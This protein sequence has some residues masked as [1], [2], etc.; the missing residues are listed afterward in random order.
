M[1]RFFTCIFLGTLLALTS[2]LL[3]EDKENEPSHNGKTLREWI[4][5]F[6][7]ATTVKERED[8]VIAIG[9]MGPKAKSAV[10]FLIQVLKDDTLRVQMATLYALGK[11][12]PEAK[13]AVPILEEMFKKTRSKKTQ[14]DITFA[15]ENIERDTSRWPLQRLHHFGLRLKKPSDELVAHLELPENQGLMVIHVEPGSAAEKVGIRQYDVLLEISRAEFPNNVPDLLRMLEKI[16]R[17]QAVDLK[18]VR[19]GIYVTLKEV[20]FP[21]WFAHQKGSDVPLK[22]TYTI[23]V[24]EN[25]FVGTWESGDDRMEVLGNIVRGRPMPTQVT[26]IVGGSKEKYANV[27]DVPQ[28]Q[29]RLLR[30]LLP[31]GFTR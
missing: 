11:I 18:L 29:R 20:R 31:R 22:E 12:G 5:H 1:S 14:S 28:K 23:Q 30:K 25:S 13:A 6:Q 8:A 9:E 15:L 7:K 2:P 4:E 27:N 24:E 16:K 19:K 21:A 26:V 3:G 17:E 10:P